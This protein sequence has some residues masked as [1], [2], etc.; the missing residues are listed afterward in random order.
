MSRIRNERK[1]FGYLLRLMCHCCQFVFS[2]AVCC[3]VKQKQKKQKIEKML[4]T[5]LMPSPRIAWLHFYHCAGVFHVCLL[6]DQV[7]FVCVIFSLSFYRSCLSLV[8]FTNLFFFFQTKL[9]TINNI[10]SCISF[11]RS[12]VHIVVLQHNFSSFCLSYSVFV[13]LYAASNGLKSH[14]NEIVFCCCFCSHFDEQCIL[15]ATLD[16]IMFVITIDWSTSAAWWQR[17]RLKAQTICAN[18]WE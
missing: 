5:I 13:D 17:H 1:I 8:L 10:F 4:M 14:V 3:F 11:V 16:C 15:L 12:L 2:G 6:S 9:K 7:Y 18:E